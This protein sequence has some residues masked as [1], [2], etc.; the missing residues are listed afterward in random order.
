MKNYLEVLQEKAKKI[1]ANIEICGFDKE[2][3]TNVI[4]K[5]VRSNLEHEDLAIIK[6]KAITIEAIISTNNEDKSSIL[7]AIEEKIKEILEKEN[8]LFTSIELQ[9]NFMPLDL[10]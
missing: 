3:I 9:Q 2:C 5:K 1:D 4:A 10:G 6:E 7:D 8:E